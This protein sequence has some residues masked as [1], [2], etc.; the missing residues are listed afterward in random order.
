MPYKIRFI[1]ASAAALAFMAFVSHEP[2]ARACGGCF[3]EE[4]PPTPAQRS[5]V[6]DHRMAF[7]LSR[8]QTVLWDQIRYAGDPREFA[9]VLPVRPGTV[10]ELSRDEWF[11][12][13]DVSTQPVISAPAYYGRGYGCALTGCASAGSSEAA[14]GGGGGDV[15]LLSQSVIGPYE[16]VTL[17][18][19]DPHALE[20]WLS[21]HGFALP[22][23][24]KPTIDAYVEEGFDFVALRLRPDCGQRAMQPVRVVSPGAD[25]SLP[26]RM[27][28]AGVGAN[29]GITLFVIGEGRY[30]PQNF[31]V[32]AP[33]DTHLVWDRATNRSN[34]AEL[35]QAAMARSNGHTWLVEYA[36]R[37]SSSSR[38]SPRS[39]TTTT[40]AS[41]CTRRRARPS[42]TRSRRS[43][44]S[45]RASTPRKAG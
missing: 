27:V 5:V 13:L 17:R 10:V 45:G 14:T 18:A 26:L 29:V 36:N 44:S 35:S 33:D 25:P 4:T 31:P 34:Y 7:A 22:D 15:Q 40:P 37:P 19:T 12:A 43:R 16:R 38:C 42:P 11:A 28:A 3:H 41:S 23:T 1:S 24:I 8:T 32:T 39:P 30:E 21:A 9:W 2:V 20:A 6:T